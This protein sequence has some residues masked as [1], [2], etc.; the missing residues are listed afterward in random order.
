MWYATFMETASENSG[1][2]RGRPRKYEPDDNLGPDLKEYWRYANNPVRGIL[3]KPGHTARQQQNIILAERAQD[4]LENY[5]RNAA[6]EDEDER[7]RVVWW[8]VEM[9]EDQPPQRVL[10]ELGRFLPDRE[11]DFWRA[12]DWWYKYRG[13]T[14]ARAAKW[15]RDFR[16]GK[17]ALPGE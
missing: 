6:E 15:I 2:K 10:T 14:A 8:M 11:E 5:I 4:C 3:E 17:G 13:T 1:R 7:F 16:L 9:A 12:F